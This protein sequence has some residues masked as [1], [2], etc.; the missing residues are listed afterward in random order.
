MTE[1]VRGAMRAAG[2]LSVVVVGASG[3]LSRRKI[4]PALFS[5][6]CRELLPAEFCCV[7]FARSEMSDEA[8]RQKL[9]ENLTCRYTPEAS[10]G[11]RIEEFL[12]HCRYFSGTYDAEADY[13]RIDAHLREVWGG[14]AGILVVGPRNGARS[15]QGI[16]PNPVGL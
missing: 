2:P 11:E 6:Y 8:F 14:R 5:L 3:D 1:S 7:G 13:E 12:S 4:F 16:P 15:G 9:M 10:C